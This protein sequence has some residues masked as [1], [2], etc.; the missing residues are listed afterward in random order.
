MRASVDSRRRYSATSRSS[1]PIPSQ[2]WSD[3]PSVKNRASRTFANASAMRLPFEHDP[4]RPGIQVFDDE[5]RPQQDVSGPGAHEAIPPLPFHAPGLMVHLNDAHLVERCPMG[6]EGLGFIGG[7][8][9]FVPIGR[10]LKR[11]AVKFHC[12][13]RT[14]LAIPKH[15]IKIEPRVWKR[16]DGKLSGD[17]AD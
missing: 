10:W 7:K 6:D 15:V 17:P 16:E 4:Q 9:P 14:I 8:K 1:M 2:T 3:T 13:P 11:Q 5:R 12:L